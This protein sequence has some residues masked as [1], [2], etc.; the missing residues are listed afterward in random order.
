MRGHFLPG[1][2]RDATV[3]SLM[4]WRC[5]RYNQ[6]DSTSDR[7]FDAL[8]RGEGRHADV[9]VADSQLSGRGTRGRRWMS[10][11]GGLYLSAILQSRA[12]PAPGLW[13]IAG[14]LA[15]Y[16]TAER[17]SAEVELDWPND[18]VSKEGAKVAGV[19]AESRGL[20]GTGAAIFVLGIGINVMNSVLPESLDRTQP[21][22]CLA[23]LGEQVTL[24]SVELTLL[25]TLKTRVTQGLISVESLYS[26]FYDRSAQRG[27]E[28]KVEIAENS[29]EGRFDGIDP[30]GSLRLFDSDSGTHRRVSIAYA[31][32]MRPLS[33]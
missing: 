7:A 4:E 14:A 32:S 28:V 33:S 15:A 18:L 11:P 13:T 29:V 24:E 30:D 19:L 10:Q 23:E 3:P 9:F 5:F 20:K 22:T 2:H 31:R 27:V 16:D 17:F 8:A 1:G 25:D 21:T 26:D 12:M 6:V